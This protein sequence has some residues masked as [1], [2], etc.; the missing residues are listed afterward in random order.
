MS[1][2][3]ATHTG[4]ASV[5]P[6]LDPS[7][8][9][10]KA[11]GLALVT[12]AIAAYGLFQ[13]A[14]TGD[15]RALVS[16]MIGFAFW[17]SIGT[18]MLFLTMIWYLFDAG[19]PIIIRRQIEHAFAAFPWLALCFLPL[20]L[21]PLLS[22]QPGMLWKW[23]DP[24]LVYPG[25]HE[26]AHD[27]IFL[28]KAGYL[29]LTAFVGRTVLYLGAFCGLALFFRHKSFA[30]DKDGD[31]RHV[32]QARIAAA[33]GIVL[34]ALTTTFAA[35]DFMMSLSYH[36]F[37]TMYG[38][39]FFAASMRAAIAM[40]LLLC[41][42]LAAKGHLRG[43]FN[44]AHRYDLGC[45]SLAFTIFWAYISFSQYF[46]I[47][48]ANIPE[49]TF[50]YNL[51]ELTLGGTKGSWWWVSLGLVFGHFL[52]PFLILL[53]YPTKIITQRLVAISVWILSFHLLDLYFNILPNKKAYAESVLGYKVVP[54]TITPFDVAALI[55][56]GSL[57]AWAFLRSLNKAAPIPL[58]DP[59]IQTSVHH[60]E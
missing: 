45:M 59:H 31:P 36:W 57:C 34:F 37:S 21:V 4:A 9:A 44:Q 51:R 46:L 25:G 38:V 60:H 32:R 7:R 23:M 33:L 10:G 2:H 29:S 13:S 28:H 47:Y 30:L 42:Y 11:L 50:W 1:T 22:G 12:L 40:T 35:F 5:P 54:F 26:I 58:R 43:L 19:W 27:S 41:C 15:N 48:N 20:L 18:G 52:I 49:E 14:Q 53:W 55:G 8:H 56:I 16:W 24:S 17:F 3:H 6:A 39:W